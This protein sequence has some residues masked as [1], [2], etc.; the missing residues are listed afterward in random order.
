VTSE[1]AVRVLLL[2]E[3][4]PADADLVEELLEG[5]DIPFQ[6]VRAQT[7]AEA[8]RTLTERVVDIILLDLKLPDDEGLS[9]LEAVREAA[10]DTPTVVLTASTDEQL[11][12]ACMDAGA[13]DYL[14]KDEL[15]QD[16]LRRTLS[17]AIARMRESQIRE[18]RETLD[19]F[20]SFTSSTQGLRAAAMAR[21]EPLQQ[22]EQGL[23]DA[24]VDDYRVLFLAHAGRSSTLPKG[25]R[26]LMER[27]AISLC[28]ASASPHDLIDLHIAALNRAVAGGS[29]A[30]SR[31][32][33]TE[34]RLTA[35]EMMGLLV[36][37]YRTGL[38]RR[39]G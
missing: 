2:V 18:L 8:V 3:D 39:P 33:A 34:S 24:L 9:S 27:I 38:Q 4:E 17:Y 7:R 1:G 30:Q 14:Y 15:R 21:A 23:F 32:L 16:M 22:R 13:Q 37:Y 28:D 20:R 12:L 6:V 11:A 25:S 19:R 36:D 26:D 31:A 29:E 35:L 10:A 5:S